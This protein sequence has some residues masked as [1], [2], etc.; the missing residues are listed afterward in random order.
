MTGGRKPG[1]TDK[2]RAFAVEYLVDLNATQAAIRAGYSP[3]WAVKCAA[4]LLQKPHIAAE[5]QRGMDARKKRAQ[6]TAES[7]IGE[8]AD[9]AFSAGRRDKVKALE[10]LGKYLRLFVDRM[11]VTHEFGEQVV[12]L[13]VGA[14]CRVCGDCPRRNQIADELEKVGRTD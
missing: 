6:V 14:V 11:E 8:L 3:S 9:I 10:L 2:Q 7:V 1:L 5:I 4:K 13:L 12:A